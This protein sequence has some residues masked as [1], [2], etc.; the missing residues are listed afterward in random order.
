MT[1]D[2]TRGAPKA[3]PLAGRTAFVTGAAQGLGFGIAGGL[4]EAGARVALADIDDA[5]VQDAAQAL[6]REG[7]DV[8]ALRLDVRDEAGFDIAFATVLDRWGRVDVMVNNAALTAHGSLWDITGDE[9][10]EVLAVNLRGC[11]F[12]CRVA[13]RHMRE[14]RRGGRIINL[15]SIAGQQASAAS[16]AHYAASKA[17]ILALTRTF[18]TELAACAVTV[19]ALAPSAVESPAL[20]GLDAAQRER[21]AAATPLARFCGIDEVAAA[22][23]FLAGDGAGYITGA[24][25]DLNGGRLMR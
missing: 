24:T 3:L 11:F 25:L 6:R 17:G 12:G 8:I 2:V 19:N 9:W 22:A 15:S 18:A 1:I 10:D 20:R 7:R 23:V 14:A 21:L 16:G 5:R 13:G 4:A